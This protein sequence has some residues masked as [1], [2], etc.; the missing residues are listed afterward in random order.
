M[1]VSLLHVYQEKEVHL[2]L[3]RTEHRKIILNAIIVS[4][5]FLLAGRRLKLSDII[6]NVTVTQVHTQTHI[7]TQ[8]R[9]HTIG[10]Q[11]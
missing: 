4:F 2:K 3:R 10:S 9:S 11:K 8:T 6:K 5:S 1:S 7:V